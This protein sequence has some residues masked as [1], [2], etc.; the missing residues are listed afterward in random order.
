MQRVWL[1]G[2]TDSGQH[3][4]G[5]HLFKV[6]QKNAKPDLLN[7]PCVHGLPIWLVCFFLLSPSTRFEFKQQAL[8]AI[9]KT[10]NEA[11]AL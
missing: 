4:T 10:V 8:R 9:Q 6:S 5:G 2:F 1:P 11:C 3:R 7:A